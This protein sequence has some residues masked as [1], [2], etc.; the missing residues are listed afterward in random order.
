MNITELKSNIKSFVERP[1]EFVCE[2][3]F[4]LNKNNG[5][6][7]KIADIDKDDQDKLK[8]D[9]L[10]HLEETIVNKSDLKINDI[11]RVDERK[12]FIFKYDY[13]EQPDDFTLFDIIKTQDEFDIFSFANDNLAEIFGVV[14][15]LNLDELTLISYKQNYPINLYKRDSK[16]MGLWQSKE[17]L[18]QIPNDIL[19]VYPNFDFFYL[20]DEL[21]IRNLKVLERQFS[22]EKIINKKASE[23][24]E[25]I[26]TVDWVEDTSLLENRLNDLTFSRKLSQI[27][28]HSIVLNNLSFND[29][30]DFIDTFQPLSGKINFNATRTKMVLTT[31]N[32]QN[33][34]LKLLNDDFLTSLLTHVNYDS[35]NKDL[36]DV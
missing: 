25:L 3:L 23:A 15:I 17:R 34:F 29:I 32:S 31:K 1:S 33:L 9:F 21:F 12:N 30:A 16:A 28:T 11:S 19:K 6:E 10:N 22:F 14:F 2:V 26:K 13:D 27:G 24:I 7:I 20:N 4:I 8:L 35:S 36:V 5:K 18:V